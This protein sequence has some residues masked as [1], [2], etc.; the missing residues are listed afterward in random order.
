MTETARDPVRVTISVGIATLQP[1]S[2][3]LA[4]LLFQADSA[5]YEAKQ[6][7][8]NRVAPDARKTL[9]I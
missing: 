5:L 6:S 3:E 1:E 4:S 9:G 8:R 7:G 2:N